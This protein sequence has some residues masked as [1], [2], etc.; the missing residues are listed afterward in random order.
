MWLTCFSGTGE[1]RVPRCRRGCSSVPGP[2]LLGAGEIPVQ[3]VFEMR[4]WFITRCN[5]ETA[6]NYAKA[7][8]KYI[9]LIKLILSVILSEANDR[10]KG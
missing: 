10:V 9:P 1:G 4:G 2:L 6:R 8:N 3:K 5:I 7:I